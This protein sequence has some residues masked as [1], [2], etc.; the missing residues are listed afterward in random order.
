[1]RTHLYTSPK[2]VALV[3]AGLIALP[4][5]ALADSAQHFTF[6]NAEY[7]PGD[8][9]L[10]AARSFAETQ[11]TPGLAMDT[12][13]AKVENAVAGC[14]TPSDP[15]A[16][17]NCQYYIMDRPTGGSLGENIWSV[18]LVPGPTGTLQNAIVERSRS[19]MAE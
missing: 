6:P 14:E 19:G 12:A 9:G 2:L 18:K 1:M 4:G 13:V 3:F 17:I 7:M 5:V 8:E 11:L 10:K 16:T 15:Q